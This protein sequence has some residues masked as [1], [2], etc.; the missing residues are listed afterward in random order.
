MATIREVAEASGVSVATVSRVF[1]G[2]ED[3]ASATRERVLASAQKL[4]YAP[5]MAARTL[6]L[7]RLGQHR[8]RPPSCAAL[9]FPRPHPDRD[10]RR[11]AGDEAWGRP[12]ARLSG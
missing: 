7:R 3:V 5:S 1:N 10:D 8:R 2:Y 12:A 11:S 6:V 4:D 9:A